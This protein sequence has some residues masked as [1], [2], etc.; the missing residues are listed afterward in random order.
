MLEQEESINQSI[1]IEVYPLNENGQGQGVNENERLL[2]GGVNDF[3]PDLG[4]KKVNF[5]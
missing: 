5:F 2:I 1:V 4:G 3:W